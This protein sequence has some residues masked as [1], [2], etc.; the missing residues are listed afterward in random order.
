[1]TVVM[2]FSVM[3]MTS[4][5]DSLQGAISMITLKKA[6]NQDATCVANLISSMQAVPPVGVGEIGYN[7][8][9]KV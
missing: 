6:M 5:L 2:D 9:I 4:A 3:S 7:M 1:M 8:D